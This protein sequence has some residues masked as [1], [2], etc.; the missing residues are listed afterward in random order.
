MGVRDLIVGNIVDLEYARLRKASVA[1]H[2]VGAG[3]GAQGAE[4]DDLPTQVD[5]TKADRARDLIICDVVD[6]E[7]ASVNVAQ[8]QSVVPGPWIGATAANCQSKPTV[9]M[10]AAPAIWLL[11]MS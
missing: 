4:A 9:P 11:L 1:H 2:H 3:S 5:R 8:D 7:L 10:K 6:L